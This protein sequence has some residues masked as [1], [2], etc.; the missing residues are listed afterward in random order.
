MANLKKATP[1]VNASLNPADDSL[2]KSAEDCFQRT[3]P[4]LDAIAVNDIKSPTIDVQEAAVVVLGI[5]G[6]LREPATQT[7]VAAL[8]KAGLLDGK[9]LEDL[10]DVA[11]TAWFSRYRLLQVSAT[12]SDASLPVSLVEEALA[13]R[14]RML[15][16]LDYNLDGDVE[17]MARLD[18]IRL[19][20]GYLDLAN[21]L[22]ANA[23]LYR[24]RR[25]DIEHDQ[26]NYR[27]T[28]EADAR[29][30]A[31]KI[32]R[33]LGAVTTP[34]QTL[35]KSNQA[36]AFTLLL[37]H[38]EEAR[39]AGRFLFYYEDGDKLF[40]SLFSAVRSAPTPRADKPAAEP[41]TLAVLP[42]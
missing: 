28:D 9:L 1:P 29:R 7:K 20:S 41:P 30:L 36:R 31:D 10:P 35:W 39:R 8:V 23:D 13:L 3:K 21:D 32:L 6:L 19:G 38:H 18:A 33:L 12:H 2:F 34:E 22:L 15:K 14:R 40:P 17:A 27:K 37:T 5:D 26:K 4:A 25:S 42:N 11:R 24:E 16:T